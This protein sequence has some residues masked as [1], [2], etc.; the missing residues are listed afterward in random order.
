MD[1]ILKYKFIIVGSNIEL[2]GTIQML[3]MQ[4]DKIIPEVVICFL[5]KIFQVFIMW[6]YED[7]KFKDFFCGFSV[8]GILIKY[9]RIA[10]NKKLIALKI[11]IILIPNNP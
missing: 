4:Y 10:E 11:I 2:I 3:Y 6:E 7:I 8:F 1:E 5:R 9:S